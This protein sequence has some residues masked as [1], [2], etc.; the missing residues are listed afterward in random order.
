M[1]FDYI[2][3]LFS[4][5]MAID[6][7]TATTLVYIKNQGIVLKEPS[8]VAL[9]KGREVIEVGNA[10]KEMIG[11]TPGDIFA[12]RPMREGVIADFNVTEKMLRY[13]IVKVHNRHSLISPRIAISVPK[14]VTHVERRA[15][16][17]SA[18]QAGAREVYLIEEPMAA[19][20]GAGLPVEEPIGH[21][22]VDIGGG[23]TEVAVISMGGI[24]VWD[25]IRTAGDKFDEAIILHLRKAYNIQIGEAMAEKVKIEI[26]CAKKLET[27]LE[28]T[29]KG[30]DLTTGLPKR[31]VVTS[32]E[33]YIA[34]EEPISK[35]ID[36]I[37]HT[38]ERTK[39]ELAADIIDKGI[40]MSGGGSLLRSF[41]QKLR[42]ETGVPVHIAE[43]AQECVVLG[44]GKMLEEQLEILRRLSYEGEE[45]HLTAQ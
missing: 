22:I 41:D 6:L 42:D 30:T 37:K 1:I 27:T 44:A 19:A 28:T 8:I 40:V 29:V 17:E 5:D 45:T 7:G 24:V 34:L 23:T 9:Y 20:I 38:L 18:L 10:A 14:G 31:I 12:V 36:G 4:N 15:V 39:P 21:M 25:S 13:F 2:L 43:N 11:K 32:D 16:R 33:M 35:I 26:G 3:G